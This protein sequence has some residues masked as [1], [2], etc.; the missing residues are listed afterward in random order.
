METTRLYVRNI[1]LSYDNDIILDSLKAIGIN[2][3]GLLKYARARTPEGH[4]TYF[5]TGDRFAEII[6]P[7]KPLPKKK[8][9]GI[10]TASL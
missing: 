3:L 5:K 8:K 6:V 4:L 2:L 10:F 7:N 1:F 9:M